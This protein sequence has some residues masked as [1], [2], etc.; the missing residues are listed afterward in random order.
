[1]ALQATITHAGGT[2]TTIY[3]SGYIGGSQ[4]DVQDNGVAAAN[5]SPG[6]GFEH[7]MDSPSSVTRLKVG[8]PVVIESGG[9]RIIY[10]GKDVTGQTNYVSGGQLVSLSFSAPAGETMDSSVGTWNVQGEATSKLNWTRP[11]GMDIAPY[12]PQL[13]AVQ[14]HVTLLNYYYTGNGQ[15]REVSYSGLDTTGN[16]WTAST[17]FTIGDFKQT[18]PVDT[19]LTV[20]ITLVTTYRNGTG[21]VIDKFNIAIPTKAQM[22]FPFTP[23]PSISQNINNAFTWWIV[24]RQKYFVLN[25]ATGS[26]GDWGKNRKL[27]PDLNFMSKS[28]AYNR[29][30]GANFNFGAMWAQTPLFLSWALHRADEI[31]LRATGHHH[32]PQ[33]QHAII[34]GYYW[35][36][37]GAPALSPSRPLTIP[38]K[39]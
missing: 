9:L 37:E 21:P 2:T 5:A 38:D 4:S 8:R 22:I 23:A 24:D 12:D 3:G 1:V 10:Q 19:D 30:L 20:S 26:I 28:L 27:Y 6:R 33:E 32:P 7:A 31:C 25:N 15:N 36:T 29:Q 39:L 34:A 13:T 16:F 35:A 11:Y 18:L 17:Y 14:T